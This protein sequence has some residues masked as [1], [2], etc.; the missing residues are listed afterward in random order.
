[1][2]I[3][4]FLSY[5]TKDAETLQ[6]K[7][8]AEGLTMCPEIDDV[9]YW[10]E[11]VHDDII[12]YMNENVGKC[13]VF[14]LF[15]SPHA[16][17]SV[18]VNKEW[19]AADALNKPIIP[20]FTSPDYIPPL[21][22]SRLGIQIDV[23]NL[24]DNIKKLRRLIL[25]KVPKEET[26]T[27][28][29]FKIPKGQMHP[30]STEKN[31]PFIMPLLNFCM[32][33]NLSVKNILVM[34]KDGERIKDEYYDEPVAALISKYGTEFKI[35]VEKMQIVAN[36]K[37][38]IIGEEKSGKSKLL[39][40]CI[41]C[42][43]GEEYLFDDEYLPTVGVDYWVKPFNFQSPDKHFEI[44]LIFWDLGGSFDQFDTVQM[45]LFNE[46]DGIFLVGDLTSKESFYRLKTYYIPNLRKNINGE[47][48][49]ILLAN[50]CDLEHAVTKTYINKLVHDTGIHDVFYTSAKTGENVEAGFKSI[51]PLIIG[52]ELNQF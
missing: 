25:K 29:Q 24:E 51:I 40:F 7:A 44:S 32:E 37:V 35:L 45:D 13:D 52:K 23:F 36:F 39:Q 18:P 43:A 34:S 6:I 4:V 38:V 42:K 17:D 20:M 3:L 48:P 1:M 47:V 5:A 22:S 27:S 30:I 46:I 26:I 14:V 11:D 19:M 33:N 2:G 21:L 9:L 16:L 50:K 28:L 12:A 49:M 10:Q 15:C 41:D 8:L 31:V